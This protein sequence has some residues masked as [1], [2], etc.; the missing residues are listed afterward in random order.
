[1]LINKEKMKMM[2]EREKEKFYLGK[3]K[4]CQ[5]LNTQRAVKQVK[6]T[7]SKQVEQPID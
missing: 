6:R 3:T 5:P 2:Q 4:N 1:M 7:E